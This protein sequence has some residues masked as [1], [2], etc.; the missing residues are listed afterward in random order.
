V[1][2][3]GLWASDG[4]N[5]QVVAYGP[6]NNRCKVEL[7]SSSAAAWVVCHTPSGQ[8]VN[9]QFVALFT[10]V[11][12]KGS[13]AVWWGDPTG[14][15]TPDPNYEAHVRTVQRNAVGDYTVIMRSKMTDFG[16]SAHVTAYGGGPEFCSVMSW[17]NTS[18]E[19]RASVRC[20]N[21]A[22]DHADSAF[23]FRFFSYA[24]F[25]IL[26]TGYSWADNPTA[27]NYRPNTNYQDYSR[28][29]TNGGITTCQPGTDNLAGSTGFGN[30]FA[31]FPASGSSPSTVH[32]TAYGT[33]G[34]CK[35]VGWQPGSL[36]R[37][38][39]NCFTPWGTPM[40][41]RFTV[42]LIAG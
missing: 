34:Y 33:N 40:Q 1:E 8:L 31:T 13:S 5:V 35:P 7:W 32:V 19:T 21:T 25:N 30:Y 12:G 37:V 2:F 27:A 26:R 17:W 22:G 23:S 10:T 38:N 41:A 14:S 3:T 20:F 6:S 36:G 42:A 29:V 39:V 15:G 28:C 9:T 18:T 11:S 16:G 24:P 4:G